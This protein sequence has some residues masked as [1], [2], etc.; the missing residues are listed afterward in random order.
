MSCQTN[1]NNI[2]HKHVICKNC[3]QACVGE[4]NVKRHKKWNLLHNNVN[5]KKAWK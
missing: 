3:K 1:A 5:V 2:S 4:F